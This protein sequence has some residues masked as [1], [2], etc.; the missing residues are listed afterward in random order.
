MPQLLSAVSRRPWTGETFTPG[1]DLR[2]DLQDVV[3]VAH[4]NALAQRCSQPCHLRENILEGSW[5]Q[6]PRSP[7]HFRDRESPEV[8][9]PGSPSPP[10]LS[11]AHRRSECVLS[12][13]C[14]VHHLRAPS[15]APGRPL[16]P[17]L[18][19]RSNVLS[20]SPIVTG[21]RRCGACT[22]MGV[23]L[24]LMPRDRSIVP[25]DAH[26]LHTCRAVSG[27]IA[28]QALCPPL[29]HSSAR[30]PPGSECAARMAIR[31]LDRERTLS[32]SPA[33]HSPYSSSPRSLKIRS[34]P[35]RFEE[36]AALQGLQ[37]LFSS[38]GNRILQLRLTDRCTFPWVPCSSARLVRQRRRVTG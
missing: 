15:L 14:S 9:A 18:H 28:R 10:L 11:R 24:Q 38:I 26:G 33:A 32:C 17:S 20:L 6:R 19:G 23:V 37:L 22:Y 2:A 36:C 31:R 30:G 25:G 21:S 12:I 35:V 8:R 4:R 16:S 13:R 7:S 29:V 1:H 3:R 34:A 27:S 5:L